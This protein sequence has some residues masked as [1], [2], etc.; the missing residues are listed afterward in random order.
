MYVQ[1]QDRLLRTEIMAVTVYP[2]MELKWWVKYKTRNSISHFIPATNQL[3]CTFVVYSY[4]IYVNN[5]CCL[6]TYATP[7]MILSFIHCICLAIERK[8]SFIKFDRGHLRSFVA[9]PI[10][11]AF[12]EIKR[13]IRN[14]LN[15]PLH[16]IVL[17]VYYKFIRMQTNIHHTWTTLRNM[18]DI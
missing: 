8:Y 16:F 13:Y 2:N 17:S 7:K 12:I 18:L 3:L 14:N 5:N 9:S 6:C 11:F 10:L 15:E 1:L 4:Q